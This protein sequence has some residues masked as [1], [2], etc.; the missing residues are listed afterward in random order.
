MFLV[1]VFIKCLYKM[2]LIQLVVFTFKLFFRDS[3]GRKPLIPIA[4]SPITS[5]HVQPY[6]IQKAL[7]EEKMVPCI[8][9]KP[10]IYTELLMTLPDFVSNFFPACDIESCRQ[11]LTDV[12][13]IDLYQG[14]R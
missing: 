10:Y 14:N 8:N 2:H 5:C 6:Q 9:F 12:L 13:H 4:E 7:L 1:S 11:V 3:R